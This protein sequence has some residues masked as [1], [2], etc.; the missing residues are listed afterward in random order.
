MMFVLEESYKNHGDVT[1]SAMVTVRRKGES[2]DARS[3]F[4]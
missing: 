3:E 4:C 1:P 2:E